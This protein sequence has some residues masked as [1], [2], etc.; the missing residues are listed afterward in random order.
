MK[1]AIVVTPATKSGYSMNNHMVRR[2]VEDSPAGI[3][4][5]I[6]EAMRDAMRNVRFS[7]REITD[8]NYIV[9]FEEQRN[10]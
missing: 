6:G 7:G 1:I 3:E 5:V 9:S 4:R 2:P 10:A 8:Y